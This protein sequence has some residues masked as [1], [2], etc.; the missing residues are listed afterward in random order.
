MKNAIP[1]FEGFTEN[2]ISYTG[3]VARRQLP[4]NNDF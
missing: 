3:T 1:I 4:I 2:W